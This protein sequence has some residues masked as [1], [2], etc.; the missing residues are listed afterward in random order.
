[1]LPICLEPD[2]FPRSVREATVSYYAART[3]HFSSLS[4]GTCALAHALTGDVDEAYRLFRL[5]AGMDLDDVKDETATGLHTASQGGA[6]MAATMGLAG[7][8]PDGDTLVV[9]PALPGTWGA[10]S[11]PLRHRGMRLRVRMNHEAVT[12]RMLS[13]GTLTVRYAGETT[14]H[15]NGAGEKR[16]VHLCVTR[17][18]AGAP[19]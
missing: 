19:A 17:R 10:V 11:L 9:D 1:V 12:I 3:L 5:A 14:T 2:A 18:T 15:R 4:P 8:R 7:V 16:A 6:Y 13:P